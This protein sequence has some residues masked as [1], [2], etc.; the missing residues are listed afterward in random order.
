MRIQPKFKLPIF[1]L[2]MFV[3]GVFSGLAQTDSVVT[4]QRDSM[5]VTQQTKSTQLLLQAD[6]EHIADSLKQAE[7]LTQIANLKSSDEKKKRELEA[8]IDSLQKMQLQRDANIKR[9]VDSLRA[10]TKGA[11]VIIFKDTVFYIYSKLGPF[12]PRERAE[13][14]AKKVENLVDENKYRPKLITI[15]K[16]E[17]SDDVMHDEMILLSIIERDA[18]W[19][20]K[21]QGALAEQYSEAIKQSIVDYKKRTGVWAILKQ[22]GML[23]AV[24]LIF[25]FGIKY[26]NRGFMWL[27]KKLMEKGK[28]FIKGVKFKSYEFISAEKE[29][30]LVRWFLKVLKWIAI[31]FAVYLALPVVFSIFPAT[32]GIAS[33]L[34][35][36][37]LNPLQKFGG[38]LIGYIPE[39]IAIIVIILVTRYFVRFLKF[40]S[41]EVEAGKLQIPG[42]YTD[43]ATPTFNLLKIIIYAFSFIIIFPY[44]PGSDSPVFQGVSVFLGLLISLGSSSAIGN[45]IAGLVI[46]YMRAF[47]IGDRVKI[48]DTVGDVIEKTML[49]T[50]LRTIKNE[51]VTIPNSAIMNGHT[52]NYSMSAS[53]LGLILN[54]TV[55]IGYDAPWRKVHELLI[56]AALKTEHIK[57]KPQPFVLQTSLDDF[58]VSYQI[59]AYTE[60]ASM[61]AKIYSQLHSNI[62][63]G[64]N[65]GG[66]EIL[67]PHYRAAR[68]GNTVAMPSDYLPPDYKPPSFNVKMNPP[69]K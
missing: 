52:I 56:N 60:N 27:N 30:N 4:A 69:G 19:M 34:F 21:D 38:G 59:N 41:L 61:A 54:S 5:L 62:Q 35:G 23:I 24:L 29:E 47:K 2:L 14:V 51:D 1:T 33:T 6:A 28:R 42:F 17:E 46:T 13:S 50:R 25:F 32:K 40:L 58:Y 18:F 55:T 64:F 31:A 16:N 39:L 49:V 9:Q 48:G 44:L 3:T 53:N 45:I 65:E 66:I 15:H 36:Y 12:S 63:D 37:I 10:S 22:I 8:H 68:D 7:L 57:D 26:M 11:P 20:D 43:W 67:S